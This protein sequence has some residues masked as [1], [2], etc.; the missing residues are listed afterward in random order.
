[1]DYFY[2]NSVFL[3]LENTDYLD[4]QWINKNYERLSTKNKQTFF[5]F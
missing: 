3:K 5:Y 4:S 1:M 2:N